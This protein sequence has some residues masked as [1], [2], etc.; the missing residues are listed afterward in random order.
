MGKTTN[1]LL[2]AAEK[3]IERDAA[4]LLADI[5]ARRPNAAA[6][7]PAPLDPVSISPAHK[8]RHRRR[9]EPRASHAHSPTP[10]LFCTLAL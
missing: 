6:A 8:P 7:C 1:N 10:T 2:A 3:A 4:T 9:R 5:K